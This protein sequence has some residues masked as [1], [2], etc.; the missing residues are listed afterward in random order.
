MSRHGRRFPVKDPVKLK[1]VGPVMFEMAYVGPVTGQGYYAEPD[2][3]IDV[4]RRDRA[5]MMKTP[6]W[7]RPPYRRRKRKEQKPV[8][9]VQNE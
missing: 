4:E 1:Y 8:M 9:E 2:Q 6:H 7:K 5:A 3:V